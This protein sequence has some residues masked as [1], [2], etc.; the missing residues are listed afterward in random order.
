MPIYL[1]NWVDGVCPKPWPAFSLLLWG[2]SVRIPWSKRLMP[3][4]HN[5]NE[6]S[7]F[8]DRV[9]KTEK[10]PLISWRR[11]EDTGRGSVC[12]FQSPFLEP[13][14]CFT[15]LGVLLICFPQHPS[16][17]T[18]LGGVPR[19]SENT[20]ALAALHLWPQPCAAGFA[21]TETVCLVNSL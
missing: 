18:W 2:C 6:M 4:P 1:H 11:G 20:H 12:P 17:C 16:C 15:H 8:W 19:S 7:V 9:G 13:L 5:K 14:P 21:V 10:C 3:S